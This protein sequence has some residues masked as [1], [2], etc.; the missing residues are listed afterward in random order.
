VRRSP[1]GVSKPSWPNW[2]RRNGMCAM[3]R[4]APPLQVQPDWATL[5]R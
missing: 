3:Q 1:T 5:L 4:V 2:R